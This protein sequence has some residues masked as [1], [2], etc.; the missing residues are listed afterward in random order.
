MTAPI[1]SAA[2]L[3]G[4][5][6]PRSPEWHAAR[7]TRL[8]GSEIAAVLG[9]SPWESRFS[10]WHRKRGLAGEQEENAPMSWG[11]RLETPIAEAF[12]EYHPEL[13]VTSAGTY[14][15]TVRDYQLAN[16]DRLLYDP[17][18]PGVPTALLEV[19]TARDDL[20]WGAPGTDEIPVYYRCQ[21]LWYL[22]ALGLTRAYV[23][24]LI[25]G[26]DY[27]EYVVDINPDDEAVQVEIATL[28]TEGDLFMRSVRDG[29]RPDIDGSTAT[30]QTIRQLPDG[31]VDEDVEIPAGLA[32][33]YL[34]ALDT[35]TAAKAEKQ[36]LA[37]EVLDRI[38]DGRRAAVAGERIATRVVN[39]DG[40]TK[41][42]K[43]ARKK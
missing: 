16:P 26:S 38:G 8:G 36:R 3:L 7:A 19:K 13:V 17:A 27:R 32:E 18:C 33:D 4:D 39:A 25:S 43:P 40:T 14:V 12:A 1:A 42:L 2:R 6:E 30:Y 24:V 31:V 9:L 37:G 11:R 22:D 28:G 10:L 23:A 5:W 15:S 20:G 29:V 41:C 34:S 35:Y 21:V